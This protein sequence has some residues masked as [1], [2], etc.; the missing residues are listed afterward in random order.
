MLWTPGLF[1]DMMGYMRTSLQRIYTKDNLELHGL[2]YQPDR[3]NKSVLAFVHGMGGNFYENKFLDSL[4]KDLTDNNIAFCPFNNRGNSFMTDFLKKTKKGIGFVTIGDAYERFEDCLLDIKAQIDFLERQ[5]FS[6]IHLSGHSLGAP[7]IAYYAAET[8]DKRIK[9]LIFISPSDML[10]SVREEPK[11]FKEDI[12]VARR[13]IKQKKGNQLMPRR[14][15]DEYPITANTYLSIFG[16][17]S[18]AGVFNFYNPE[19]GFKTLSQ[20]DCPIFTAM[21]RKDDCLLMPIE[22]MMRTIK[23][24]AKA[25]PRCEY[26]IIGQAPHTYRG[27]EGQLTKAVLGW[28]KSF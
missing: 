3:K 22:K 8:R 24:K 6:N 25:S 19:Y 16:D 2:L 9:S 14:V 21:G 7:K 15:W 18:K 5:G 12:A 28:I 11:R 26:Q 10:G 13:M 27:F 4:A 17:E 20:I 1:D 23:E